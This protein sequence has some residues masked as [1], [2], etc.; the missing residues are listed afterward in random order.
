MV[1]CFFFL[2]CVNTQKNYL[3]ELIPKLD[4]L[5]L[6]HSKSLWVDNT[7]QHL[8]ASQ[9]WCSQLSS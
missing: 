1:S 4:A 2:V 5:H 3:K 6:L 7:F 8:I 9:D